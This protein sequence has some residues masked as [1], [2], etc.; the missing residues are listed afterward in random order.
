[1]RWTT[2]RTLVVVAAIAV[3]AG[4]GTLNVGSGAQWFFSS[5]PDLV[6]YTQLVNSTISFVNEMGGVD[7]QV[8]TL[9]ELRGGPGVTISQSIGQAFGIGA[10]MVMLRAGVATEGAWEE[11][12]ENLEVDL[13]LEVGMIAGLAQV[14]LGFVDGL[15]EI[16]FA[17]GWGM[18]WVDHK[19]DFEVL[20]DPPG[21]WSIPFAPATDDR[22]YQSGG[23]VGELGIRAA[24]PLRSGL[25]LGTEAGLRL[26]AFGVPHSN[27]RMLDLSKDGNPEELDLSGVWVGFSVT[28]RFGL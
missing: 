9:E 12:D 16:S 2:L 5:F 11:E 4:A 14:S 27:G 15:L 23:F 7:G 3:P 28:M 13:S 18:A 21:G 1:M 22:R 25:A 17:G 19:S 8:D 20:R 6:G 26:A 10:R 24:L